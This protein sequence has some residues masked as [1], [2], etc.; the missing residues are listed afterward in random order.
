MKHE[1][2]LLSMLRCKWA[3]TLCLASLYSKCRPNLKSVEFFSTNSVISIS[4][5]LPST[6]DR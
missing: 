1:Y 2:S 3:A 6:V 4:I 5:L